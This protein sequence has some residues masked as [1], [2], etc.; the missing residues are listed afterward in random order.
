MMA[1]ATP[2]APDSLPMLADFALRLSAGIIGASLMLPWRSIPMGYF[3]NLGQVALGLL[4][5]A[6]IDAGWFG[7]VRGVVA[8]L[9]GLA[10]LAYA[11][12]LVWGL[13]LPRLAV[14]I[15]LCFL[16]AACALF[17]YVSSDAGI[18]RGS[19]GAALRISS[20]A[21]LGT[22]LAAMLLG[23]YYLTAPAMSVKP[24]ERLVVA[25]S[26]A[27]AVRAALAGVGAVLG[28][29]D[30][31]AVAAVSNTNGLFLF[32]RWGMGII[33]PAIAGFLAWQTAKIR[34]TQSATGILY[35]A[36]TLVLFGELTAMILTRGGVPT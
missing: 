8:V 6:A 12:T 2:L 5:L 14:P 20:A 31:S 30:V 28:S 25:M 17:A 36:M 33:G 15:S 10:V 27:L 23:H 13:G 34:S 16:L 35:I 26:I 4:V 22:T 11:A 1:P 21:L 3:R 9:V 7:A 32:M 24:L 18:A 29:A 19:F